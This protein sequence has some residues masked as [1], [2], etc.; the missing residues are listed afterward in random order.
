MRAIDAIIRLR[1]QFTPILRNVNRQ[2]QQHAQEQIRFGKE[3]EKAGNAMSGF[4][5]KAA[6]MAAPLM[7]AAAAGL[8]LG[9]DFT[10]GM[11]KVSTLVDTNVVDMQKLRKEVVNLSN[12]SGVAVTDLAE[13][14]Y[15][16]ISAG[17]E[18]GKSVEFLSVATK[19]AKAGFTD[20]TTAIDG[21][22]TVINAYG[23][24]TE[25]AIKISDQMMI[26]QNFGKTTINEMSKSLGNVIPIA[27]SL[28]IKTEE[29]FASIAVLTK[30]GIGTSEAITGLKAAFSNIVKPSK[31]AADAAASLGI[32]FNASG[33]KA[34]GLQGFIGEIKEKLA[35]AAPAYMDMINKQA[36]MQQQMQGMKK[37]SEEYKRLNKESKELAKSIE[38]MA[39][40]SDSPIAGFAT[41]FG[42]VEALNSI[43][44]LSGK[45]AEDFQTALDMMA[46]SAGQTETAYKKLMTPSEEAKI[47]MVQ[48][49]NAG[50]ELASGLAPLMKTGTLLIKEFATW[51]NSLTEEQKMF[52]T[53][54]ARNVVIFILLTGAL[55]KGISIAGRGIQTFGKFSKALKA[56]GSMSALLRGQFGY[57]FKAFDLLRK[58]AGFARTGILKFAGLAKS[59]LSIALR[60]AVLLKDGAGIVFKFLAKGFVD[61]ARFIVAA[62]KIASK[63]LISA[64]RAIGLAARTLLMNPIG[65]AV[66]GAVAVAVLLYRHW[67]EI[68]AAL[69]PTF[70]QI[71]GGAKQLFGGLIDFVSGVFTGNWGK[72]WE[73]VKNIFSGAFRS[74]AGL[75]K[76]PLNAVIAL[77]N[78]AI[79]EINSIKF[80]A[81]EWI[82]GIGGKTYQ[83]SIPQIPMLYRGAENWQGGAAMIHD[84][85]AEIVDLPRGSRVYPHARSLQMA[86]EEGALYKQ[87]EILRA[88]E[89]SRGDRN[90][91]VHATYTQGV[92]EQA[93][94]IQRVRPEPRREIPATYPVAR[95]EVQPRV[96]SMDAGT[97]RTVM[98][99]AA[100]EQARALSSL[101][102][103]TSSV[104]TARE[105]ARA[106]SLLQ[107]ITTNAQAVRQQV[108]LQN[109]AG[110]PQAPRAALGVRREPMAIS[111]GRPEKPMIAP[112]QRAKAAG[113]QKETPE[114]QRAKQKPSIHFD[115]MIEHCEIRETVD[116]KEIMKVFAKEIEKVVVNQ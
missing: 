65:L 23:L 41:M 62:G 20:T 60:A 116:A 104:Q 66:M 92:K 100:R 40:A 87:S 99:T 109:M 61:T 4:S 102:P 67:D 83:P 78:A 15:Q 95:N 77:I 63:G 45:G 115:K 73:G 64:F 32:E 81:P 114:G 48:L 28:D 71:V 29:L 36:Q 51:L 56:A 89:R 54:A 111:A 105:Q 35:N 30:N 90:V 85:G 7:G 17:V 57:A 113:A 24:A 101:R 8:K 84:R 39:K 14:Q 55:G 11:A 9:S 5:K 22:T 16:A 37:G 59:G 27:A 70:Q 96:Q 86:R 91:V 50:M 13:A 49:A 34:K 88:I 10:N 98:Q 112:A 68:K 12:E 33:L 18:A 74:L 1:D 3:V 26:A 69:L 43:L 110:M 52:L 94:E 75:C 31:E 6:M 106:T 25:D 82:P 72:A 108:A 2:M 44:V 107:P 97:L 46:N 38:L 47:A 53:Y 19:T 42:S 76:A 103:I 58:G 93:R 21:L 80:T 79:G